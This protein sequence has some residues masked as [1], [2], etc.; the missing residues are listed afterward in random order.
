MLMSKREALLVRLLVAVIAGTLIHDLAYVCGAPVSPWALA[1]LMALGAVVAF[2][3]S[4]DRPILGPYFHWEMIRLARKKRTFLVRTLYAFSLLVCL[5]WCYGRLVQPGTLTM[6]MI[7]RPVMHGNDMARFAQAFVGAILWMQ[8]FGVLLLTPAYIAGAIAEEREKNNLDLLWTTF[9]TD[10]EIVLG[11]M[12][13]RMSHLAALLLASFPVLA[14]TQFFGGVSTGLL[15]IDLGIL[16]FT[17]LLVGSLSILMSAV[18]RTVWG[19]VLSTYAI[20]VLLICRAGPQFLAAGRGSLLPALISVE[21]P[22][23]TLGGLAVSHGLASLLLLAGAIRALRVFERRFQAARARSVQRLDSET[24]R[25]DTAWYKN[26]MLRWKPAH[27][28]ALSGNPLFWREMY[29]GRRTSLRRFGLGFLLVMI[30]LVTPFLLYLRYGFQW[31]DYATLVDSTRR[32][33]NLTRIVATMLAGLFFL[34]VGF[35][36]AGSVVRERQR[37][38]LDSLL[39]LPGNRNSVL[40]AKWWASLLRPSL[41]A[42]G[43]GVLLILSFLP[44]AISP[45]AAP[46]LFLMLVAH[47]AFAASL[48]LFLSVIAPTRAWANIAFA[49]VLFFLGVPGLFSYL[50]L[51]PAPPDLLT[52]VIKVGLN[53]VAG[54]WS[55]TSHWETDIYIEDVQ[56]R[57]GLIGT[58]LFGVSAYALWRAARFRFGVR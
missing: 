47:V 4:D 17:L 25:Y 48:G 8:M 12:L 32:Q 19:A 53:P 11:K 35:R 41:A 28:P 50:F 49:I 56:I 34:S 20:V 42:Q 14:L 23:A 57:G 58:L 26:R 24:R 10:R 55:W 3:L 2:S 51:P 44:V 31:S 5:Y 33:V 30:F 7:W 13:G 27:V 1:G 21:N 43:F 6:A 9:L 36:A 18:S 52:N 39:C 54:W 40:V 38:T 15:L 46:F 22:A 45:A 29:F 37:R 16:A